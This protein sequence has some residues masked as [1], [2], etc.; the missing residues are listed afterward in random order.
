MILFDA[1]YIH[2]GG[3]KTILN[4]LI[5]YILKNNPQKYYFIFDKR[6]NEEL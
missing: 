5:S 3:G 4:I 6:Y 1:V 2:Q